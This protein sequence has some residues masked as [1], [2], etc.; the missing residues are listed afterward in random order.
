MKKRLLVTIKV[1]IWADSDEGF[2]EALINLKRNSMVNGMAMGGGGY[3]IDYGRTK[4]F[5]ILK[6]GER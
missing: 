1:N 5:K 6:K 2:K 4:E 3:Q